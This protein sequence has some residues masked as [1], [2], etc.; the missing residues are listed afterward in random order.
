MTY[1]PSPAELALDLFLY[2]PLGAAVEASKLLPTLARAG[3][4]HL[5]ERLPNY[6][7]VGEMA[8]TQVRRRAESRL[9]MLG[10]GGDTD[11]T[12]DGAG[13]PT[14]ATVEPPDVPAE[15][16]PNAPA[17]PA[18]DLP[19]DGYDELS[20]VQVLPNL[21]ALDTSEL[22]LIAAHESAHRSRR[23]ILGRIDQLLEK[24]A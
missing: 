7:A 18:V 17:A 22:E 19:I 15:R 8:V 6:R 11:R 3:R 20:A 9:G 1:R 5:D 16:E 23:T 13:E 12:D 10:L 2:A 4:E 24:Q 21:T 14:P